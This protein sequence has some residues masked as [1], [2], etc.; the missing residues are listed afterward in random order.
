MTRR[1][2]I[3]IA[4]DHPV[5]ADA[6]ATSLAAWYRVS[7]VVHSL[8]ALEG[9]LR[10]EPVAAV[11]LDL[12]FGHVNAL[13]ALPRLVKNHP[14]TRFVVLTAFGERVLADACLAAGASGF[15]VKQSAASELRVALEE[16]LQ[17]RNYVTPLIR[18]PAPQD[19]VIPADLQLPAMIPLTPRQE[20]I[21]RRLAAGQSYRAIAADMGLS[22]KTVEYHVRALRT[23]LGLARTGQLIRWAEARLPAQPID[24]RRPRSVPDDSDD[25]V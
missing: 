4:D 11:V 8:D 2:A 18:S 23:R 12:S 14:G 15:V 9:A 20:G 13:A 17:G 7:A 1:A 3:V 25:A 24:Q 5:I 16:A 10:R 22:M 6:L 19:A 21:L